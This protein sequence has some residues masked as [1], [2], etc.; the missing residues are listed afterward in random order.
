MGFRTV[1]KNNIQVKNDKLKFREYLANGGGKYRDKGDG[2]G[3]QLK[4]TGRVAKRFKVGLDCG[5]PSR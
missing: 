1:G 5:G 3:K 4:E 2:R